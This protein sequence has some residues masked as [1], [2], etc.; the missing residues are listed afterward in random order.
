MTSKV[1]HFPDPNDVMVLRQIVA[2]RVS[3]KTHTVQN[4]GYLE[5]PSTSSEPAQEQ[6][7]VK[8]LHFDKTA[9]QCSS[10]MCTNI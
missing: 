10:V 1:S 8:N 3:A 6:R 2:R 4:A 7:N 5:I 9:Y